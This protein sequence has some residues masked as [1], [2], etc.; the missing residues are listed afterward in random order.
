M[1]MVGHIQ[2]STQEQTAR[3]STIGNYSNEIITVL[4]SLDNNRPYTKIIKMG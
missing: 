3:I 1:L 4:Y 2:Y